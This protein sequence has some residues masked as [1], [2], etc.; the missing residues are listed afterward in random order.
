MNYLIEDENFLTKEEKNYLDNN[1]E[2]IPFVYTKRIGTYRRDAPVMV[3]SLVLRA[4]DPKVDQTKDRAVSPYTNFFL[5]ILIR[6]TQKYNL[7][8]NKIL[9]GTINITTKT[10]WDK[11]IV[12][13]DHLIPH[14]I[15]MLYLGEEVH[16]NLN[17][18]EQDKKTLIKT[19]IPK[20]FKIACFGDSVPHQFEYPTQG[21]RRAV[22]FTFN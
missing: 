19:V 14:H 11:T 1:F 6:F 20:N 5:N 12:H 18:Y 9:R 2:N 4:D 17:L 10:S 3:H 7:P 16:G 21:L 15:F 8:F 13:V 22:V